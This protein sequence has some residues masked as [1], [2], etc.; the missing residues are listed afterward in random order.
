MNLVWIWIAEPMLFVTMGASINFDTLDKGTIPKA[1]IIICSGEGAH[2][3]GP[4]S[5]VVFSSAFPW[6]HVPWMWG[7]SPRRASLPCS[8]EEVEEVLFLVFV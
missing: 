8:G 5:F 6:A 7:P 3:V 2:W 1:L 4:V